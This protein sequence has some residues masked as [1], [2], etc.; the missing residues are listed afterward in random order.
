M[1]SKKK[2]KIMGNFAEN[3]KEEVKLR[4]ASIERR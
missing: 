1:I 2:K 3:I 4:R